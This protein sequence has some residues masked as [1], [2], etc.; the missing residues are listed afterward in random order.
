MKPEIKEVYVKEGLCKCPV[1]KK[2]IQKGKYGWYCTGYKEGCQFKLFE[3][4]AGAK[5]SEKDVATLCSG[6][7][8]GI[9]HCTNKAGKKFDCKFSL[10]ENWQI[11]FVFLDKKGK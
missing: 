3:T 6:K 8:T 1:C 4:V 10:D 7:Q 5:F 9:K 11:K 2:D